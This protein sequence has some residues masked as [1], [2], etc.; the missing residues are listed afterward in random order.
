MADNDDE[1]RDRL[2]GWGDTEA[3][4]PDPVEVSRRRDHMRWLAWDGDDN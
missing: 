4:A 1:L 3:P 2:R